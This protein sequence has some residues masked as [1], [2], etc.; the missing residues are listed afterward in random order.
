MGE[1]DGT[2]PQSLNFPF[3]MSRFTPE[4]I[5]SFD[6]LFGEVEH[7]IQV[8]D[9]EGIVL[10][11]SPAIYTIAG[12]TADHFT[13]RPFSTW[14]HP[15]EAFSWAAH[16]ERCLAE[17][18]EASRA[19]F[20]MLASDGTVKSL[21]VVVGSGI[22][23]NIRVII[24]TLKE[25]SER[26]R[27]EN[28][29]LRKRQLYSML[30]EIS[31]TLLSPDFETSLETLLAK[32]GLHA[33]GDRGY[34]FLIDERKQVCLFLHEWRAEPIMPSIQELHGKH[35]SR[36]KW[37]YDQFK[38]DKSVVFTNVLEMP[39]QADGLRDV[40]MR[41]KVLSALLIPM[42]VGGELIGFLGFDCL[43]T[44]RSWNASDLLSLKIW[45][46]IIASGIKRSR[47]ET[48]IKKTLSINEAI[49]A[50]TGEG[51]LLAD[52][53]G[54]VVYSN[55]IFR[56]IWNLSVSIDGERIE[57]VLARSS[58]MIADRQKITEVVLALQREPG[59]RL[60]FSLNLYNKKVVEVISTPQLID[61]QVAG[62]IW[63]V[64]DLTDRINSEREEIEK[65]VARAQ[66]E[67][68]R[69]QINPHFL[70]NSLNVLCTLVHFDAEL[71]EKFIHQLATSYRYLLE[72]KGKELVPLKEEMKFLESF[73]FLLKIR[74]AEKLDVRIDVSASAMEL[75]IAPVTLQL[76]I[77]NAVKH[78]IVSV[79]LPLVISIKDTETQYLMVSNSLQLRR[80][81]SPSTGLGLKNIVKRYE[82]LTDR[83][84]TFG[85]T[86]QEWV[87]LIPLIA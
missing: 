20:R 14:L 77:E 49:I 3:A 78:N 9:P 66:F 29:L 64:R 6:L 40:F 25:P 80:S 30:T 72:Q 16:F 13:G 44:Y 18:Q 58:R 38:D 74:F 62:R 17:P 37:I 34:M 70:F 53:T 7:I 19:T 45:T 79:T 56:Q 10:Y 55:E 68:L 84:P 4:S 22:I 24:L 39:V 65:S 23:A 27:F 50:S 67:S 42:K 86:D 52:H 73:V 76:L 1:R 83:R 61:G 2:R 32:L 81:S 71:S 48:A 54:Q 82:L 47:A 12:Y 63:N 57:T 87:A 69:N 43:F 41:Q 28:Y 11:S 60:K 51:I 26:G 33:A 59:A 21:D 36:L 75:Y 35:L 15:K 5:N 31:G 85:A 46:Q 8:L